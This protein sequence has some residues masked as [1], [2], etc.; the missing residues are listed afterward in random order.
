[1]EWVAFQ[2]FV[3][4]VLPLLAGFPVGFSLGGTALLFALGGDV[5]GGFEAAFR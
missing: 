5:G 3:T 4:V 2:L 1:M